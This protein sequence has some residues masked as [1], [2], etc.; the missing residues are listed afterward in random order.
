MAE[1]VRISDHAGGHE[2]GSKV[3]ANPREAAINGEVVRHDEVEKG[4]AWVRDAHGKEHLVCFGDLH[5]ATDTSDKVSLSI[6]VE[7]S[8]YITALVDLPIPPLE[9]DGDH[10][11]TGTFYFSNDHDTP[12]Q[13]TAFKLVYDNGFGG[14]EE[15]VAPTTEHFL[16]LLAER[17]G[18]ILTPAPGRKVLPY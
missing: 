18:F 10:Y 7:R 4:K 16:R 8:G 2:I 5:I 13:Q 17:M 15:T 9:I 11:E 12:S 14:L 6:K 3:Y 1:S